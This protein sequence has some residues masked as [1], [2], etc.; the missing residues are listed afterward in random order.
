MVSGD[1][2]HGLTRAAHPHRGAQKLRSK[3]DRTASRSSEVASESPVTA[4]V[5]N[6]A[7][8]LRINRLP[9]HRMI[10]GNVWDGCKLVSR[11]YHV[12]YSRI[13]SLERSRQESQNVT[14]NPLQISGMGPTARVLSTVF[15][16]GVV[17]VVIVIENRAGNDD[18]G[19][20]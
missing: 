16:A 3:Y 4:T 15:I 5:P 8:G 14:E 20:F 9:Q 1:D 13:F 2:I 7:V 10:S 17:V 12:R 19:P 6:E 18:H 11:S